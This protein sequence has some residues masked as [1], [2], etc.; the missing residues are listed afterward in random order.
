VFNETPPTVEGCR[1]MFKSE[2]NL[3]SHR[4]KPVI[5]DKIRTWLLYSVL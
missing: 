4:V 5:G 1:A 2:M 3:L